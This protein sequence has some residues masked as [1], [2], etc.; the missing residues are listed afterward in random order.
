M[1]RTGFARPHPIDPETGER[2]FSSFKKPDASK[3]L[4]RSAFAQKRAKPLE[5]KPSLVALPLSAEE[6]A[7]ATR[8]RFRTL[9]RGKRKTETDPKYL[10]WVRTNPCCACGAEPPNHAH[11][12]ILNGRGKSQKAP[13]ARTL[14]FCF[15]DH[16][17]FHLV[18]GKFRGWTREQ[19]KLF[20]SDEISRLREIWHGIQDHGVA[21]EPARNSV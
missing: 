15:K 4:E 17:D 13:D 21:Q 19:R 10:A 12:E 14:A 7:I 2:R 1:R 11:H 9:G 16:D 3:A 8:K 20:Q 18:R 5:R 6:V